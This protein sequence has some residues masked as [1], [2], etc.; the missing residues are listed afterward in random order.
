MSDPKNVEKVKRALKGRTFL[1][2]GGNGTLTRQ[3]KKLC[4]ALGLP[5]SA[6]EYAIPTLKAKGHF[7]SLPTAYKVDL[8]IPE[9][10]LAIEVDGKT[11]K[12][13]KW[14]FLDQRKT[15]I[16]NF[17]GWTVLRFWNKEVDQDLNK[18]VQ[19]TLSTISKLKGTTTT[20]RT[21]Y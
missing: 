4:Q 8:A 2:R 12:T 17:L 15:E 11:H 21:E 16:L 10:K 5:K 9:V 7:P 6:M 1:A 20:S 19:I 14:K 18:C 13:K 3:Q